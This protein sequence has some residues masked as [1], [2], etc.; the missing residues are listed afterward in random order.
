MGRHKIL[1]EMPW[2]HNSDSFLG[3]VNNKQTSKPRNISGKGLLHFGVLGLRSL[4]YTSASKK[5]RRE[6]PRVQ[7]KIVCQNTTIPKLK[8]EPDPVVPHWTSK[9]VSR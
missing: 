1:Q 5:T 8:D 4:F 7:S 9:L 3:I 6:M 2:K